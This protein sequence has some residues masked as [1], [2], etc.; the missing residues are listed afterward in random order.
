MDS[1]EPKES[2]SEK[3]ALFGLTSQ[4]IEKMTILFCVLVVLLVV[5]L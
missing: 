4:P 3:L 5:A 1:S 2:N